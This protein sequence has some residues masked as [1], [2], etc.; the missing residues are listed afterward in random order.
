MSGLAVVSAESC[1]RG[2]RMTG[3]QRGRRGL[4]K[5]GAVTSRNPSLVWD[6]RGLERICTR[7]LCQR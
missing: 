3:G 1:H 5:S 4:R 6:D 2:R 7:S